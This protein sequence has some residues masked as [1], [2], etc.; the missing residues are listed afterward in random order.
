[1]IE[2]VQ[3]IDSHFFNVS[4]ELPV[5]YE[6]LPEDLPVFSYVSW[7]EHES[8]LRADSQTSSLRNS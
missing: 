2:D 7:N 1:M 5:L 3:R 4:R 6:A 8:S